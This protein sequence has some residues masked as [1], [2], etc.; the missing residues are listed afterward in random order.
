MDS[1][2][3]NDSF[4]SFNNFKKITKFDILVWSA[5]GFKLT[6]DQNLYDLPKNR[7]EELSEKELRQIYEEMDYENHIQLCKNLVFGLANMKI[8]CKEDF[9]LIDLQELVNCR[10]INQIAEAWVDFAPRGSV[11][12]YKVI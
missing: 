6:K 2:F 10:D 1:N 5:E 11:I 4:I 7:K 9:N 12:Y 3:F 8:N